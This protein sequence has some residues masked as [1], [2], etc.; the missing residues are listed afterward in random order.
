MAHALTA[1]RQTA[2]RLADK[3]EIRIRSAAKPEQVDT[4]IRFAHGVSE[5]IQQT[6]YSFLKREGYIKRTAKTLDG[7][8]VT[9][10]AKGRA[11]L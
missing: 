1:Q 9:V 6:P 4:F 2:L 11:L 10:T 3:G 7:W 8:T 5:T